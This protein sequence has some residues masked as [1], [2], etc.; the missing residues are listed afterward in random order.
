MRGLDTLEDDMTIPMK[1]KI[2]LLREF[3]LLTVQDGW[4]YQGNGPDEKD[5]ILLKQYEV[6]IKELNSL[7]PK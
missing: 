2:K 3:H 4:N 1:E 5:A 6:V 7:K